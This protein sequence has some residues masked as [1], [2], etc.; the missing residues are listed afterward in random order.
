MPASQAPSPTPL[1]AEIISTH[2]NMERELD[3]L[4]HKDSIE[5]KRMKYPL[6][7]L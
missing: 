3:P 7:Q 2:S 6:M 4:H 5:E 1:T